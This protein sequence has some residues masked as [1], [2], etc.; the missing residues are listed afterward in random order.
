MLVIEQM[1]QT[2]IRIMVD[3]LV[4]LALVGYMFYLDYKLALLFLSLFLFLDY[5]YVG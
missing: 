5:W 3:P 1:L 4:I 2:L